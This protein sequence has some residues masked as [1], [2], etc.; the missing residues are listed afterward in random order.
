MSIVAGITH[1]TEYRYDR[2]VRLSAQVIRLRPAPH[3]RTPV[4]GYSLKV[5]PAEHFLNWLQ[6]PQGNWM[7]RVVFPD[8]VEHFKVSVD[9][10]ARMDVFNPFDFFIEESAE[11]VPFV[12][13]EELAEELAPF[14]KAAAAGPLLRE[15]LVDVHQEDQRTI[16]FLVDLNQRLAQKI[17]YTIR[18]EPGVQSPEE[19]LKLCSGSCR[20]SAWL[21]VQMLRRLGFASR[22][23][24]GYLIQLTADQKALDG[25][26]GPEAD[27]TDLHAWSEVYVPGAGWIG[28]D[29]TSG[30]LA[31]EGHIPVAA[32]PGPQSA[33]PISGAV[34]ECEVEFGH[35]MAV[36]R[37]SESPRV[38]KPYSP[39][40]WAAIDA[41][42][43]QVDAALKQRD[44]RLTMGGEPTFVAIDHPQAEE[45][46]T[47]A[48]GPTKQA[49]AAKLAQKLRDRF[50]PGG[51]ISYGQGK[52]YPGESLPR[53]AYT[54]LW[55]GDAAPIWQE[56]A[57][58]QLAESGE[59]RAI[60]DAEILMQGIC[61][62]L[63]LPADCAVAAYEDPL[64]FLAEEAALP[65]GASVEDPTFDD[66]E[67]RARVQR[68]FSRPLSEPRGYVLPVQCWQSQ[69]GRTW[70]SERWA[71]RR[72][73]MFLI[74]GDSPVGLRM[75][76]DSLPGGWSGPSVE[77]VI[78]QDPFEAHTPLPRRF[79]AE[80]PFLS[81]Q[82]QQLPSAE[83][84]AEAPRGR[85]VGG[86]RT[87]LAIEP[88]AGLLGVFLP[89]THNAEDYL[90]LVG[91]VEDAAAELD[92]PVRI[93]GYPAPGDSRLQLIKLT[94]D[95]GVIEVNVQPAANWSELKTI[96]QTL[97]EAARETR[98]GT[99]KF[100]IDGKHTGTGGGNHIVVGG[101][102]A[103]DSPFLRRP[104]MLASM[105]RCWQNHPSLS[106]LFAGLFIGPT[107]Q[108][109]R[110]DEARED[111]LYEMEIALAQVPDRSTPAPYWLVDRLLRNL[112]TDL[113]GNTHR[114]EI[115]IDKLYSPDSPTG[116]LGL[117][118]LR[119]FEM[120]PHAQ[121]SLVQQLLVRALLAWFWESP[122]T[123]PL[124][125][126]SGQLHDRFL[127]PYFL[128]QNLNSLL[129]ELSGA[130]FAFDPAWFAPHLN[131]RCPVYGS[132]EVAGQRLELR[133]ALEAWP[134][135]GE[136][137][138]GGGTARYVDSSVERLEVRL[139]DWDP[140]RYVLA[141]NGRRVPLV[142]TEDAR[143]FVAGVRFRAW[144]PWSSLHPGISAHG[145]LVFDVIDRWSGRA[146][147]GC[148]YHVHHPGGRSFDTFPVNA[149]EAESRRLSRFFDF[150]HS[151]GALRIPPVEEN[152]RQSVTL[153]LR[154]PPVDGG[155]L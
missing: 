75:P 9:L 55:R 42:G 41:L 57:P 146:V 60:A 50:A 125:R 49:L 44:V 103:A 96:T 70:V 88:K 128:Q 51:L 69:A 134:T 106:Y 48:V 90:A 155:C 40:Q 59:R 89:P 4:V 123:R 79:V 1:I 52:W 138:G 21:L 137:P 91:A 5:E 11:T 77:P 120:P 95:P 39:E 133:G 87:A 122:Y 117:V 109:P 64:H 121:M 30:L 37:V 112:L 7:A 139:R 107:S 102:T 31:G 24:S 153:D 154:R 118:E 68:A 71:F 86:I 3:A 67:R 56:T 19:T 150:G 113:T 152:P 129:G 22:F 76:L 8:P 23:V 114:A 72:G 97:Y 108:S 147:G 6:D 92:L 104:D 58:S 14:R 142:A 17:R 132:V 127:L 81:Q 126:W 110:I 12:Y 63:R 144:Q 130:G 140:E 13:A 119:A 47:A 33:A 101:R 85:V 100:L 29:P 143:D 15:F 43:E 53:W 82:E 45:W 80:Q 93:E 25:P 61:R 84:Q 35:H 98:L 131:F 116:R 145:P 136:E 151:P 149:N 38:T 62:R 36:R 83:V 65:I 78:P 73:K 16:D 20:D 148:R 105:V 99:E 10:L 32:T 141:C 94:P 135:M 2:P 124:K 34:D 74:P 28:L 26:S 66:P 111:A 54:I 27:F 46:N 115:C 18:M